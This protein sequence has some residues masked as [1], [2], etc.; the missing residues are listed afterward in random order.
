MDGR[1]VPIYGESRDCA[2][3]ARR[4]DLRFT[5]EGVTSKPWT[6]ELRARIPAQLSS[7]PR[8]EVGA[9]VSRR[10]VGGWTR[11]ANLCRGGDHHPA[12]LFPSWTMYRARR[13]HRMP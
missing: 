2:V 6:G 11:Q 12:G 8:S 1:K 10:L 7:E 4:V 9:D 5:G 3:R 13:I